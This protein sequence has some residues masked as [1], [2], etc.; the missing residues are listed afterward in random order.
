MYTKTANGF[1]ISFDKNDSPILVLI[2]R[3]FVNLLSDVWDVITVVPM[4]RRK[5]QK[6]SQ[7]I[8]VV[9]AGNY[10]IDEM[11]RCTDSEAYFSASIAGCSALESVQ[12]IACIRDQ[13]QVVATQA[14]KY[15][16]K[17]YRRHGLLFD[18]LLFWIDLGNLIQVGRELNWFPNTATVQ[19]ALSADEGWQEGLQ[20]FPELDS[21]PSD[22]I[23]KVHNLRN[24]LHPGKCLRESVTLTE[25]TGPISLGLLYVA[26]AGVL[27][28]HVRDE[29]EVFEVE[30]HPLIRNLISA[31]EQ[32]NLDA[33]L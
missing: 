29:S 9:R 30:V 2:E 11:T 33:P 6:A 28:F 20:K 24:M 31:T 16:A 8:K 18:D 26:L 17:K 12:M 14:W 10:Y 4:T 7:A 27:E 21:T 22:A 15:F 25:T 13:D 23:S 5:A 3:G 32:L 19:N 1:R